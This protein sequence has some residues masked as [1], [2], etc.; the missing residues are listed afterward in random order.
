MDAE[1]YTYYPP[2]PLLKDANT[3]S[4][5]KTVLSLVAFIG[6]FFLIGIDINMI[7]LIVLVLFIHEMGH[8]IAM[9]TFGYED[10]GMFFIPLIGAVVT[11]RKEN[12]SQLQKIIVVLA[13]PIPGIILG[14]VLIVLSQYTGNETKIIVTGLIF[15][16]LNALNLLPIDPLDGG[17]FFESLFFSFNEKIKVGFSLI[18]ALLVMGIAFY[19]QYTTGMSMQFY[20]FFIIGLFMLTR[21]RSLFRIIKIRK[22][23]NELKIGLKKNY[24]DLSDKEYWQIRKEYINSSNLK[25]ILEADSKT[26]DDR[27]Q[28]LAPAVRNLLRAPV[29]YNVTVEGKIAFMALWLGALT[30]AFYFTYP[31]VK[32][33]LSGEVF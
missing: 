17:K 25:K 21:I 2:K 3:S 18:S 29:D 24:E 11:G 16:V 5:T 30:A 26:Y 19:Y 7:F 14:I 32:R 12:V 9:K 4:M 33:I 10:V 6:V 20:I 27:E 28:A 8:L 1:E 23:I 31:I 15:L 22:K 13:G